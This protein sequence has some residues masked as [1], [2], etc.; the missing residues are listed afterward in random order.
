[1][2]RSEDSPKN[3]D[4]TVVSMC[5]DMVFVQQLED[6]TDQAGQ[7]DREH[8][9]TGQ[10]GLIML[11]LAG[12]LVFVRIFQT[13]KVSGCAGDYQAMINLRGFSIT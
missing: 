13:A 9:C 2:A 4:V 6:L 10:R 11:N 12:S 5:F 8:V 1:M 7:I 3:G